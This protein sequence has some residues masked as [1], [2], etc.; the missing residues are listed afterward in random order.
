MYL[1]HT[2]CLPG[3]CFAQGEVSSTFTCQTKFEIVKAPDRV[4]IHSHCSRPLPQPIRLP[5]HTTQVMVQQYV[6]DWIVG[7]EDTKFYTRTYDV[8]NPKAHVVFVHG[9]QEHIAR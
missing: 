4:Q 7:P 1:S 6:E 5:N 9:F 2:S 3:G 8:Q